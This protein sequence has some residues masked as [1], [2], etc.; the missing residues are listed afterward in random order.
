MAADGRISV[1]VVESGAECVTD[2]QGNYLF[3]Q[4]PAGTFTLAISHQGKEHKL[5]VS[6]PGTP[7]FSVLSVESR[8]IC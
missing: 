4:M 8:L 2:G 3:R 1:R 7:G 5:S 6:L